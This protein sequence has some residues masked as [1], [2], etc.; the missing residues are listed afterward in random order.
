MAAGCAG[1]L[2]SLD[3]RRVVCFGRSGETHVEHVP[4]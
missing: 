1:Y 4:G 2:D 3:G